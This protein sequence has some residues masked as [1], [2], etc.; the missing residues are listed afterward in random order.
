MKECYS[1]SIKLLTRR[2][3]SSFKL[4]QKLEEKGFEPDD[5][6]LTLEKLRGQKYLNDQTYLEGLVR[7][8]A[9]NKKGP[10]YIIPKCEAEGL[11]ITE[12]LIHETYETLGLEIDEMI[13]EHIQ[14][15]LRFDN[16]KFKDLSSEERFKQYSR[17]SRH[18]LSKGYI[19]K[20]IERYL[21]NESDYE[22]ERNPTE[23]Y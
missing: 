8:Y 5:I 3:Y 23:I 21:P 1:T 20:N 17:L 18:L 15:K 13:K 9:R 22:S 6:E 16:T 7:H 11:A 19:V 14:K 12:E 2:D 4:S 10:E